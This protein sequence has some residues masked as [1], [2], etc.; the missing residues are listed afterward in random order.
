MFHLKKFNIMEIKSR[1]LVDRLEEIL[2]KNRDA[3]KGYSKAAENAKSKN[4]QAYFSKKSQER[5]DFNEVL[6]QELV[7]AYDE[8]EESGSFTGTMHRAWMDLK[9]LFSAK[10]D[11]SMLEEAIRG[12]KAAVEEYEEILED[13]ALP[14]KVSTV[15]FNQLTK[16]R[17][18]LNNIK[19]LEDLV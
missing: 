3:E 15:I 17:A 5:K 7:A 2:E 6:K 18:D 16:I 10:N 13:T 14:M 19:T 1:K 8:I 9:A 4:L 12:D 11:K